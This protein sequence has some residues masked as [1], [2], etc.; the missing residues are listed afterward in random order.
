MDY[1]PPEFFL[2]GRY[3][4]RPT[5]VWSVGITLYEFLSGSVPFS[6]IKEIINNEPFLPDFLSEGKTKIKETKQG[7]DLLFYIVEDKDYVF[8]NRMSTPASVVSW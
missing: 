8:F 2:Y 1:A 7:S 3:H 5:T 4:P 6:N